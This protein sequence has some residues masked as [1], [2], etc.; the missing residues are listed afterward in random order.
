MDILVLALTLKNKGKRG[1]L[2]LT[3]LIGRLSVMPLL[4]AK[5]ASL[6]S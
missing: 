6:V 3:P 5:Y 2:L 1:I 4:E